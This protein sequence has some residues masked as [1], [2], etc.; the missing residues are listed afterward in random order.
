MKVLYVTNSIGM[1]GASV[2]I[3]NMLTH[4]I[5]EDI[6]P[7]VT[8]P[9]EG[10]FSSELKKMNIPVQIIGN[11]LEIYPK[12]YSWR[13]YIK[14]PYSLLQLT[15]KRHFAYKKLC[16]CIDK[17]KP[18]IIHTNVGPIHIGYLA[19]QKYGI[20]HIWHIREY[21]KED[22]DMHPFPSMSVYQKRIHDKS[23]HC[24]CITKNMFEHFGLDSIKD[25]VIYDGV[26]DKKDIKSINQNKES[27]ILFAGRLED[28]KG[29]K[30]LLC[31]YDKYALNGGKFDLYIAGKGSDE[32][33]KE[34]LEILDDSIK[35]RVLFL[36]ECEHDKIY[37]LMYNATIFVV[38]SRNEGFGFITAE[39]MFNGTVVIGKNTGGTKEQMDN[40]KVL[41]KKEIAFRYIKTQDLTELLFK[42]QNLSDESYMDI[43]K[44]AQAVVCELYDKKSQSQSL[45]KFYLSIKKGT[46]HD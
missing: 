31:A 5:Q 6:T 32:Y 42:V 29:I 36:G 17:F 9:M 18:D 40:G 33:K 25:T 22:F 10:T 3:I 26:I 35:N 41:A 19:A 30:E 45:Y 14:Y 23:N 1:G 2:A 11:P 39:A 4:L 12:I 27:Y 8:C 13:S 16:L 34:C 21:Q 28:A 20:P 7:M 43:T 46:D 44:S 37:E 15:W 38:P 24:I